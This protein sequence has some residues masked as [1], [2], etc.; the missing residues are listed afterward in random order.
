MRKNEASNAPNGASRRKLRKRIGGAALAVAAV[1]C[2]AAFMLV[3]CQPAS[4][5]AEEGSSLDE[6]RV[7]FEGTF[8]NLESGEW[9]DTQYGTAMNAGNRGCNACHED[10]FDVL[11]EGEVGSHEVYKEAAYGKVYTYNDCI[12]CHGKDDNGAASHGGSGPYMAA[13]IHAFHYGTP[14]FT[15]ELGGNCFSCHEMDVD[16]NELGMWDTLKYTKYIGLGTTAEG[17]ETWIG[18]RGYSTGYVTGGATAS[19]IAL[20]NVSVNQDASAPEDLYGATNMDFPEIEGDTVNGEE[21]TVTIKGVKNERTFTLDEL[22]AMPQTEVTWTQMCMTNGQNGG[23]YVTNIP[24]K[25]VLISDLVEA[26]GGLQEGVKSFGACGYDDWGL[27]GESGPMYPADTTFSIE[28]LL[29]PNAMIALEYF[30]EPIDPIDGG[31]AIFDVP[32]T[33]AFASSKWVKEVTFTTQEPAVSTFTTRGMNTVESA[34]WFTPASDGQEFKVGEPIKLDGYAFAYPEQGANA[35]ES[36]DISADYGKTWTIIAIPENY[37][38]D[39]WVRWYAEWTPE[40]PGTYCLTVHCNTTAD[41]TPGN[42]GHVLI[43]VTE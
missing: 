30:G 10:L 1:G 31:P 34:S 20:N 8:T 18:G 37:D 4:P 26:C 23:W 38:P 29:D 14:G 3:G 25:G 13:T 39:Q 6:S 5:A 12:T 42:D 17:T 40:K 28:T 43:K 9:S 21:Y 36:I 27:G 11:P 16:N 32:G 35:V 41:A 2:C 15:E 7:S 33:V 22:R 19:D 24:A